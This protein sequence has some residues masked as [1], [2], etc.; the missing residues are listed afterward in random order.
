[1][2]RRPRRAP[3]PAPVVLLRLST[4]ARVE[5]D[6]RCSPR[7]WASVLAEAIVRERLGGEAADRPQDLEDA[8]AEEVRYILATTPPQLK[9]I[10][11]A[12]LIA[13]AVERRLGQLRAPTGPRRQ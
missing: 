7:R 1:M 4:G 2:P 11:L 8:L 10:L 12:H 6:F 5:V 9:D 3:E 13:S